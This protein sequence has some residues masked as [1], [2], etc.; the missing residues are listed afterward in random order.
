MSLTALLPFFGRGVRVYVTTLA[1]LTYL[2]FPRWAS[3]QITSLKYQSLSLFYKNFFNIFVSV[4]MDVGVRVY[5][6][7]YFIS[8]S[9]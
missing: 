2:L 1:A 9:S 6:S 5:V 3:W 8:Y 4:H 7:S